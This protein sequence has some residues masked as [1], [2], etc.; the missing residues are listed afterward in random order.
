MVKKFKGLLN[1]D[2]FKKSVV[3]LFIKVIG[4]LST[5]LFTIYITQNF[6]VAAWGTIT[7]CMSTILIVSI[8]S[9]FGSEI[10]VLRLITKFQALQDEVSIKRVFSISLFAV[11]TTSIILTLTLVI[12]FNEQI[13]IFYS[14]PS[15]ETYLTI[16]SFTLLPVSLLSILNQYFRSQKRLYLYAIGENWAKFLFPLIFLVV[17]SN[18]IGD[19]IQVSIAYAISK[20]L[21]LILFF[22]FINRK[23]L[24]FSFSKSD[25]RNYSRQ[26]WQ[27]SAPQ[28]LTTSMIFLSGWIDTIIL[29]F[30][31][32]NEE[33][34]IYN[35]A[36]RLSGL[37]LMPLLATNSILAPNLGEF[38][39]LNQ[40]QTIKEHVQKSL[41]V[42]LLLSTPILIVLLVFSEPILTLFG[43]E[44]VNANMVLFILS[45]ATFYGVVTGPVGQIMIMGGR[46]KELNIIQALTLVINIVLSIILIPKYAVLGAAFSTLIARIFL[47]TLNV[48]LVYKYFGIKIFASKKKYNP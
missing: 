2:Y 38:F 17:A 41:K 5:Y 37:I 43:K 46:Q 6:G 25:T 8:I 19:L 30:Y 40:M 44:L 39:A 29:G 26:I 13:A 11:L 23:H 32:T 47:N 45:F 10:G 4:L 9:K 31:H 42:S 21:V 36:F 34:G 28:L 18:L 22:F 27:T 35:I 14:D 15:L 33:V 20:C 16:F 24:G 1:K 48:I 3:I 12:F 7:L